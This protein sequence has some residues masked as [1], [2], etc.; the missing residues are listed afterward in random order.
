MQQH[1][2]AIL[3]GY[4]KPI[5]PTVL[6]QL[7]KI[8]E[9]TQTSTGHEL[10]QAAKRITG[11]VRQT[12]PTT[13]DGYFWFWALHFRGGVGGK[14]IVLFPWS[15]DWDASDGSQNDRS[16]AIHTKGK[17]SESDVDALLQELMDAMRICATERD[18]QT[19]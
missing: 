9:E 15:Q 7:D 2:D 14:I 11:Y 8:Q 19:A 10:E 12:R 18:A 1:A 4:G 3:S 5:F 13:S 6:A 16:Q 17:V